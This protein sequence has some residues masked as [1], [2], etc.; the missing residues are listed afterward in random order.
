MN[1]YYWQGQ[2]VRLRG[3]EPEDWQYYILWDQDTEAARSLY[4]VPPPQ[5]VEACRKM[6]A[7]RSLKRGENEVFD[8]M[9]DNLKGETVGSINTHSVERRYGTFSYGVFIQQEYRGQG[10]ADEAVRMLLRYYF[11][12]LGYQKC[13]VGVYEF[14]MGS[15]RLHEKLGFQLEGRIRRMIYTKGIYHDELRYGI[16]ADEFRALDGIG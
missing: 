2:K 9:I 7:E 5:S 12:E 11:D 14:N 3:I 8:W 6:T 16:T 1:Q 10:Y 15:V 4:F 13:T